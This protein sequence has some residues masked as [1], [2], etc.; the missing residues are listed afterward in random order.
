V[1]VCWLRNA[2]LLPPALPTLLLL[3]KHCALCPRDRA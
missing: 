3:R 1:I 2:Q